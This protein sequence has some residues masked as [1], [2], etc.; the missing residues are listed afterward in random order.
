MATWKRCWRASEIKQPKR[1]ENL[2]A[3]AEKARV[4][5][6]L[7]TL[8]D[9]I[10]V[11]ATLESMLL[12]PADREPLVT[13][14]E[15]QGFKSL[16]GRLGG[17]FERPSP[18]ATAAVPKE[19]QDK[20][21]YELVQTEAA[22]KVWIDRA[23]TA[24]VV[25]F[26]TETT[27]LDAMR[28]RLV[29][30]SMSIEPC[31]ACYV[32]VGHG[33]PAGQ[34]SLDLDQA[35]PTE[36]PKQIPMERALV[37]LRPLLA[38][39]GVLKVGHNIK[40][41][42]LVLARPPYEAPIAPVDD[43]MLFSYVVDAGKNAHNMDDLARLHLGVETI[44]Y[45]DVA[46][47]GKAQVTFDQV[48]LEAARDYSAEDADVT[49]RLAQV[50][51]PRLLAERMTTVYET[52]ERPLIPIL[53]EMERTGIRVD[54]GELKRL[55]D[56]FGARLIELEKGIYKLAGHEF[57]IGSPKQL[58][59]VLFDELG[60]PGGKKSSRPAPTRPAPTCWRSWPT[61]ATICRRACSTGVNWQSSR[62]LTPTRSSARSIRIRAGFTRHMPWRS[63]IR[64]AC[65][66]PIRTCRTS[67]SG[68][69]RD[70]RSAAPSW[71]TRA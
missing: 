43:S 71:R 3:N 60:L 51:K 33:V 44:K 55:S 29:G 69:K 39:P 47:S 15:K 37:L 5:R 67:R 42:M 56:D 58:G 28:A 46:G 48:P 41:D 30:F 25:A 70:A 20:T 62:A 4:S 57:N 52:I 8:K 27:S 2:I 23:R 59:E 24:G 7:V 54:P 38:D 65:P 40:Y 45:E 31:Q 64:A 17:K 26:D 61:L 16:I 63:P 53:V 19:A 35:K 49:L 1:R 13:F 68:P 18:A 50:L 10:D 21:V 12:K 36:A 11:K 66:R 34:A 6:K 32:P 14:L 22:L 9:D